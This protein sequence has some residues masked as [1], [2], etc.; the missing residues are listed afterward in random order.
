MLF[1]A[2]LGHFPAGL[3]ERLE[4]ACRPARVTANDIGQH[5]ESLRVGEQLMDTP[6]PRPRHEVLSVA[7]TSV[8]VQDIRD[9]RIRKRVEPQS[10]DFGVWRHGGQVLSIMIPKPIGLATRYTEAGSPQIV[11]ACTNCVEGRLGVG[12]TSPHLVKSVDEERFATPF[13]MAAHT[14]CYEIPRGD[15]DGFL[16]N[17]PALDI[18]RGGLAGSGVSE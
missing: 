10:R 12:Q 8:R 5:V 4:T 14:E 6:F 13:G 15:Q 3:I 18:E 1:V 16:V 9:V 2:L 11:E 7:D 17:L